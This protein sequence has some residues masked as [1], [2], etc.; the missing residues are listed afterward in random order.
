M[1]ELLIKN[2]SLISVVDDYDKKKCDIHVVNGKIQEIGENLDFD[3]ETLDVEGK[4]V[5][6]GLID[7]HVHCFAEDG[8]SGVAPDELGIERGATTIIDA[9][10][11][12][13]ENYTVFKEKFID[14]AKTKVFT[15][16]N[17]S[18]KGLQEKRELDSLDK[19]DGNL[20]SEVVKMYPKNIVGLK[21][22]ASATV[23][24]EMGIKPI[25]M[26][27]DISRQ[28]GLPLMVHVGNM[29]PRLEEVLD[30]LEKGDI[31][32]HPFHGKKGG[33]VK[34]DGSAMIPEALKA[35][36]RGVL[37]DIGHGEAS[38]AYKTFKKVSELDFGYDSISTD[39]HRRNYEGP[40]YTMALTMSK[41]MN[42]GN[43]LAEV[44]DKSTYQPTKNFGLKDLGRLQEGYIAD[45]FVFDLVDTKRIA[46]D[47]EGDE[48]V[49]QEEIKPVYTIFSR[50]D[51]TE[52]HEN[53]I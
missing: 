10:S 23:V 19:I 18:K 34:E 28:T 25:E 41:L 13:P 42:L 46:L 44:I 29:P 3:C 17:V 51:E 40:V 52:I 47:A 36:D 12:G 6:A 15:L 49:L 33:I 24:G 11:S 35:K 9:G 1:K 31:V 38:F 37:F 32:T 43:S 22:R 5:S 20:V 2:G 50:G 21:A 39:L 45:F 16:L 14:T 48:L 27:K 30:L 53:R 7:S 4:F 26:A 8:S